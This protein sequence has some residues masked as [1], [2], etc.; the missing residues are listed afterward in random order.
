MPSRLFCRIFGSNTTRLLNTPIAGMTTEMVP[1]S[2]IDMLAGLSRWA[3]RRM[4]P[5]FWAHAA[6]SGRLAPARIEMATRQRN[7]QRGTRVS[8]IRFMTSFLLGGGPVNPD[9][10]VL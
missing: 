10:L 2:W 6:P 4:P 7:N 9:S 8:T 5:C 1:S 3:T